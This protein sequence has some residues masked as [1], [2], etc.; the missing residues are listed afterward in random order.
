M[1]LAAWMLLSAGLH[2]IVLAGASL[3]ITRDATWHPGA[4]RPVTLRLASSRSTSEG[5]PPAHA[6]SVAD[7]A[8]EAEVLSRLPVAER[9][10]AL[11]A[12]AGRAARVV[13]PESVGEIADF[14]G[15]G[16]PSPLAA[17][18]SP[19]AELD[20]STLTLVEIERAAEGGFRVRAADGE[21]RWAWMEI[22]DPDDPAAWD[23]AAR[24]LDI[25][26]ANPTL[27]AIYSRC[28]RGLLPQVAERM[29]PAAAPEH[30][31]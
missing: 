19:L 16:Q 4:A 9:L 24:A 20:A 10:A 23:A 25:I 12:R 22:S 27:T 13:R 30:R 31:P 26:Q 1:R 8:A 21:G 15:V 28:V 7:I 17:G 14:L 11:E 5:A 29:E 2:G 6:P 18:P 3:C